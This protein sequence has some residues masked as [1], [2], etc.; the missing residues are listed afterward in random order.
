M[1]RILSAS[2]I[3]LTIATGASAQTATTGSLTVQDPML[4]ATAPNAPVAGG[5]VTIVNAGD[6][7]DVLE[8]V[9]AAP[10]LTTDVELHEM[11]MQD[12][13]MRMR[14]LKEGIAIP[15]GGTV[16][17]EPGGLHL[18]LTALKAPLVEGEGHAL[19]LR[20]RDAGQVTMTF[21]VMAI[22]E[23]RQRVDADGDD[24][25]PGFT[26]EELAEEMNEEPADE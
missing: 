8:A 21:P 14:A 2:L 25:G 16:T 23:I 10:D 20:F 3:A 19:T 13:V 17:L 7:D 15:A 26:A 24:E 18:M 12:G 5:F 9:M 1:P 11:A 6:A 22:G 4:R